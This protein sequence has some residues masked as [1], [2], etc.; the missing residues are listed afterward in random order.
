MKTTGTSASSM[1]VV[2]PATT[3]SSESKR[4]A[5]MVVAICVLSPISARKNAIIVTMNAPPLPLGLASSSS[6]LS[7]T[8]SH[9]QTAMKEQPKIQRRYPPESQ[10]THQQPNRQNSTTKDE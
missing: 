6:I 10:S 5:R 4:A 2:V 9:S 1:P 3:A 8:S 7:G